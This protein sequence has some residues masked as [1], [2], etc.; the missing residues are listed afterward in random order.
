VMRSAVTIFRGNKYT[1]E[2]ICLSIEYLL[3]VHCDVFTKLVP[4]CLC[5]S[6]L[7]TNNN[8]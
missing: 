5:R 3:D 1:K 7:N 4:G 2:T 8:V 6:W